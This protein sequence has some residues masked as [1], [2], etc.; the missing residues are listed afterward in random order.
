MEIAWTPQAAQY[1]EVRPVLGSHGLIREGDLIYTCNE[2][3]RS[4]DSDVVLGYAWNSYELYDKTRCAKPPMHKTLLGVTDETAAPLQAEKVIRVQTAG[5]AFYPVAQTMAL[6]KF[7]Y[8]SYLLV[9]DSYT[10]PLNPAEQRRQ[11]QVPQFPE[12]KVWQRSAILETRAG[13]APR[14]R[15]ALPAQSF[16]R[17][18]GNRFQRDLAQQGPN[19]QSLPASAEAWLLAVL[20]KNAGEDDDEELAC[21]LERMTDWYID[22]L[23]EGLHRVPPGWTCL[24]QVLGYFEDKHALA[25]RLTRST[26]GPSP[27]RQTM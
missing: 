16:Y 9:K 1:V 13:E 27:L 25:V 5:L 3:L 26:R 11:S 6:H 14:T 18:D 7:P 19:G 24:G 2:E 10:P 22:L 12:V 15:A 21:M 4:D 20:A 23:K 8:G 17:E